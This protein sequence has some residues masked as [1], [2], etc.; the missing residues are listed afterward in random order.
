MALPSKLDMFRCSFRPVLQHP[1]WP[2]SWA[3]RSLQL[4]QLPSRLWVLLVLLATSVVNLCFYVISKLPD[5]TF[6]CPRC[7]AAALSQ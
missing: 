3:C 2:G 7:S 6:K 4:L 5:G 1:F